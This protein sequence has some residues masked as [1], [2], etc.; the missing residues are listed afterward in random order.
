MQMFQSSPRD[1]TAC[2]ERVYSCP[3]LEKQPTG[4]RTGGPYKPQVLQP[5]TGNKAQGS[6]FPAPKCALSMLRFY[7]GKVVH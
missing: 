7:P 5:M 3:K 1:R 4:L 2:M 6:D